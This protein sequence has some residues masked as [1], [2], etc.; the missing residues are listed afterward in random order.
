MNNPFEVLG[1]KSTA[2]AEEVRS[3]Y[4]SLV[5]KC[6]PDQFLDMD[7]RKA[8]Q[9]KMLALN[10]AYEEALKLTVPQHRVCTYN[11][12]IDAAEAKR[13]ARKMLRQN[14]PESALHQ[15]ARASTK[16]AEWYYLQGHILMELHQYEE[17]H[18]AYRE[19]VRRDS[20][21][22]EYR[23]GALDAA[24]AMKKAHTMPGR[25]KELFRRK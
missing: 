17:A 4:R 11:R 5:R 23:R 10:L 14:S 19:A 13:L 2:D 8:A 18:A 15:L 16:D 9:E 24:V 7:E 1:L 20:E 22:I 6:H 25:I 3:A 21:N 12:E